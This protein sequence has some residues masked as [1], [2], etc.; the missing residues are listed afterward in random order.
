MFLQIGIIDVSDDYMEAEYV[1]ENILT[2]TDRFLEDK[3]TGQFKAW[4]LILFVSAGT[5]VAS[6]LKYYIKVS[7]E[8]KS[9]SIFAVHKMVVIW[10]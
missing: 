4:H 8:F 7:A 9:N 3:I 5:L 1:A 2:N 6:K 10:G